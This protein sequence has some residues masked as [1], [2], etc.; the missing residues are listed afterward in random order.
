MLKDKG[1]PNTSSSEKDSVTSENLLFQRIIIFLIVFSV[2][3]LGALNTQRKILFLS[4][5]F[6][7]VII[8]WVLTLI[9]IR[10]ARRIDSRSGGRI[11]KLFLGYIIPIFCSLVLTTG[12][13]FGSFG[14]ADQYLFDIN[15]KPVQIENKIDEIKTA[16]KEVIKPKVDTTSKNFR[17]IDSVIA[18]SSSKP[19]TTNAKRKTQT[20]T[21]VPTTIPNKTI[22]PKKSPTSKKV[23]STNFEN[24]DKILGE[25]KDIK[26]K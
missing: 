11:I 21:Q 13:I 15:I 5:L 4:I 14:F 18:I 25:K 3:I 19:Q 6:L 24:I 23:D 2:L 12:L 1:I 26:K 16:V 17:S 7:G 10:T 22:T 20:S 9:I 8:C